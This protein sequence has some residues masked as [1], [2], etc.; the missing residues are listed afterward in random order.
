MKKPFEA[1]SR[2][3]FDLYVHL[4]APL[5]EVRSFLRAPLLQQDCVFS[6][7]NFFFSS[8]FF[9]LHL[10]FQ[11]VAFFCAN[12]THSLNFFRRFGI[13]TLKLL[14]PIIFI[15]I[16][17]VIYKPSKGVH[18]D[19]MFLRTWSQRFLYCVERIVH[20]T[21]LLR[22]TKVCMWFKLFFYFWS[23]VQSTW[24]AFSHLESVS[25]VF[26]HFSVTSSWFQSFWGDSSQSTLVTLSHLKVTWDSFSC[27]QTFSEDRLSVNS[28]RENK[29]KLNERGNEEVFFW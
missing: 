13:S 14:P 9:F 18:W 17:N 25:V 6:F 8:P 10:K 20:L 24:V 16:Y 4:T 19:L 12:K 7:F 21:R 11:S 1:L 5:N 28:S 3:V 22:I 26:S 23:F 27:L 29:S 2:A 15:E